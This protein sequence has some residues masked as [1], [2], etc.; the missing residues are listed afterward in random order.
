MAT[1]LKPEL[2]KV[3]AEL[4]AA[5]LAAARAEGERDALRAQIATEGLAVKWAAAEVKIAKL[6]AA[7]A[8]K[9]AELAEA[10][11]RAQ[12][13]VQVLQQRGGGDTR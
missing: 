1:N 3:K 4:A 11:R 10:F 7:L 8:A 2:D 5:L 13:P 6:E 9:D 12:Q